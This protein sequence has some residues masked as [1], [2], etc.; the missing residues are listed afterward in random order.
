MAPTNYVCKLN[1]AAAFV[2]HGMQS[3]FLLGGTCPAARSLIFPG[4]HGTRTGPA[5]DARVALVMKRIVGDL[6]FGNEAPYVLVG[7]AQKR[8]HFDQAKLGVP[9]HGASLGPMRGLV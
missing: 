6:V 1:A 9:L 5:P 8:I 4:G 2:Y 3:A 7:P